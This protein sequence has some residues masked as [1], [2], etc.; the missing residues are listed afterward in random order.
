MEWR[1]IYRGF[2]MGVS[3]LI[4]GVSG[5]TIAVLLGIYDQLIASINGL[6]SKEWRKYLSY[7][8]PLATGVVLAIFTLSRMMEWLLI[9]YPQATYFFFLGL[10]IGILPYLFVEAG[11]KENFKLHHYIVL[12]IGALF[13]L[14]LLYLQEDKELIIT[15]RSFQTYILF[16]VSGFFG[17]AAMI[18]PGVSGSMVLLVLGVYPT[19]IQAISSLEL[20]V[21]FVTAGGIFLGI[22][23]MSKIIHYCLANY[24]FFTFAFIIGMV[25]GSVIVIFPGWAATIPRMLLN[26]GTFAFGLLG[27]YILGRVEHNG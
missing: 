16:F 20:S 6:F 19:I 18:L 17:S 23:S 9:Y 22:I 4:P 2:A 26:I 15:D 10:I 13:I 3:D 1:N 21:I 12:L 5:G 8:I 25:M 11:V 27:A 7:L 24:R 14:T